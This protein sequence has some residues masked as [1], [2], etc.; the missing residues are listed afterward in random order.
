MQK[1]QENQDSIQLFGR[2]LIATAATAELSLR[3]KTR[4]CLILC[5]WALFRRIVLSRV[6]PDH[7][8]QVFGTEF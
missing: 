8:T 5:L 4:F 1:R 6:L 2:T 3:A 7:N